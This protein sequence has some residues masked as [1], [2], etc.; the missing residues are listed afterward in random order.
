MN[1]IRLTLALTLALLLG[2]CGFHLRGQ[3]EFVMPFQSLYI[4]SAND[5]TPFIS[6]LKR[7]L[8]AAGVQLADSPDKAQLTLHIVSESMG[9]QILS[10]S[11]AGRV[12]EYQLRFGVSFRAFDTMQQEWLP[13]GEIALLRNMS[14]DDTQILA[15]AQEEALLYQNMVSDAVQQMLRRL[16]HARPRAEDRGQEPALERLNPGAEDRLEPSLAPS[17]ANP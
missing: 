4:Q 13:A 7:A 14:Y 5:Y 8:Q 10:L 2:A 11:A 9:K 12:R 3:G 16:K 1:P 15:K 6:E 17:P